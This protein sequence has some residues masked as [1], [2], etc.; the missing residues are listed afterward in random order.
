MFKLDLNWV[1]S[2][3]TWCH[4]EAAFLISASPAASKP[5]SSSILWGSFPRR[6]GKILANIGR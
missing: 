4:P 1:A 3:A 6:V 2:W 5:E